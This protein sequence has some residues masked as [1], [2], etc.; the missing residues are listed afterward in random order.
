MA[1]EQHIGIYFVPVCA[2][3]G[4]SDHFRSDTFEG[5]CVLDKSGREDKAATGSHLFR[6]QRNEL[7]RSVANHDV[8]RL[9]TQIAGQLLD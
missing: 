5:D 3:I 1:Q 4:D 6:H 9:H 7:R 8:V 2:V